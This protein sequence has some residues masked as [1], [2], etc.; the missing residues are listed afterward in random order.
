[1]G[2]LGVVGFGGLNVDRGQRD[3]GRGE[4]GW[5]GDR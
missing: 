1:M 4:V 5:R 2:F 3:E